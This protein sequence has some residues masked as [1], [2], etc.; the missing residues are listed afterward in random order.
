MS[1]S[2]RKGWRAVR[3]AAVAVMLS[4]G[5]ALPLAQVGE[6]PRL[7]GKAQGENQRQAAQAA[8]ERRTPRRS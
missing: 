8:S 6:G 7:T 5:A 4:S 2:K 3:S 1:K